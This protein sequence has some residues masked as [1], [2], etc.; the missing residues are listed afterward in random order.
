M[1]MNFCRRCGA[2]LAHTNNHVFTCEKGHV[3]FANASPASCLWIINDKKEILVAVRAHEPGKGLLDAPGGFNDGAETFEIGLA[4]ELEEEVG[5]T[6]NDYTKPEYLLSWL[7]RYDYKDE[8]ID[9][10]SN[11]Y[12]ARLI[13]NPTLDPQDDIGEAYFVPINEVDSEKIYFD[14]V[15]EGF[16]ALRD[17]VNPL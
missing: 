4:R 7:D 5:L 12:W 11:V 17:R 9:V 14:A 16:L 2:K 1:E 10:L 3:I 6:S 15:R 8:K 13:G